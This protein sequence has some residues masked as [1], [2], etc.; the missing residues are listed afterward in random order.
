MTLSLSLLE[1]QYKTLKRDLFVVA[2]DLVTVGDMLTLIKIARS[3]QIVCSR[4]RSDYGEE[5]LRWNELEEALREV[6][7]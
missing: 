5:N 7:L 3:A 2:G 6:E 4:Y 1:S